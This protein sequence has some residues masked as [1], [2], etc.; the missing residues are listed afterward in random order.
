LS[1]SVWDW[2]AGDEP[3]P[4]PARIPPLTAK[5]FHPDYVCWGLTD[6]P[7][8][9]ATEH[10]LSCGAIGSGKTTG[11]RLFLQSIAPRFQPGYPRAEQLII[12]DA[13][14]NALPILDG[15]KIPPDREDVW[16]LN[17][18]DERGVQWDVGA[19]INSPAMAR[20]LAKL[21]IPPEPNTTAP[22]FPNAARQI[23]F[24]TIISLMN[25]R[26]GKWSLRDLINAL[27]SIERILAVCERFPRAHAAVKKHESDSTNFGGVL[28]HMETK[29]GEFHEVA[30]LW[31][32]APTRRKF[33]LTDFLKGRGVLV[34]GHDPVLEE[35]MWPINAIILQALTNEILR[36]PDTDLPRHWFVLDEFRAMQKVECIRNLLNLGRSKGAS[37]LLGV[38]SVEG[39][40]EIYG[41][42]A[43]EDI[44]QACSTK[45]FLKAGGAVTAEW[46]EKHFGKIRHTERST[47]VSRG[48]TGTTHSE[49]FSL[50]DR[51]LFLAST[52][53]SLPLPEPGGPFI[54]INDIPCLNETL[55]NDWWWDDVIGMCDSP[56]NIPGVIRRT[57]KKHE[58]LRPWN[59]R[60]ERDFCNTTSPDTPI[61]DEP[62]ELPSKEQQQARRNK[63]QG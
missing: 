59:A 63:E 5:T 20:Y 21:L 48:P 57:N 55:I 34:L 6:L 38:Q 1:G 22:Y 62:T 16:I 31:H 9:R 8:K 39:L 43:T 12:F 17:P 44:L 58:Y 26:P 42:D 32:T 54:A 60:E 56:G 19:V 24:W 7:V 41:P 49:N 36:E 10:F 30:A 13:K 37:V 23:V 14:G 27:E 18:F 25:I 52:F 53:L 45:T 29:M 50:Q 51:P 15:L 61:K 28:S 40:R 46:A 3:V 47:G 11:I 4:T 33:S 2:F 35:S